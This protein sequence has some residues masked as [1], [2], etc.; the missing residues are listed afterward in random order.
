MSYCGNGYSIMRYFR[1]A[2]MSRINVRLD[3]D[4][5]SVSGLFS[6]HGLIILTENE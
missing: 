5:I 1:N 4:P 6:V 2:I 3:V